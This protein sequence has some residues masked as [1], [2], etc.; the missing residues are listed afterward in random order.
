M[1]NAFTLFYIFC[2]EQHFSAIACYVF[3]ASECTPI[4]KLRNII[5]IEKDVT[6]KNKLALAGLVM[7]IVVFK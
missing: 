3:N 4:A 1:I 6:T 5:I 2:S 7:V